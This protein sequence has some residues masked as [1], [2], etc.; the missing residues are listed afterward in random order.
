MKLQNSVDVAKEKLRADINE[1]ETL[2]RYIES[3]EELNRRQR[4]EINRYK[5]FEKHVFPVVSAHV[6]SHGKL[7]L[8]VDTVLL[9]DVD[10]NYKIEN[11]VLRIESAESISHGQYKFVIRPEV[12]KNEQSVEK[13]DKFRT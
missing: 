13:G 10:A 11:Q 6:L 8:F 2:L 9:S 7:E 4:E 12:D 1:S 5:S 3:L